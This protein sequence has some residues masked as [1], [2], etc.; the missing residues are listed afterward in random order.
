MKPIISIFSLLTFALSA[1]SQTPA[2]VNIPAEYFHEKVGKQKVEGGYMYTFDA[3]K[4]QDT[5]NET[6]Q[7]N[8][9]VD[10][11]YWGT[12]ADGATGHE[13]LVQAQQGARILIK[14]ETTNNK[15]T[16]ARLT[17]APCLPDGRGFSSDNHYMDIC[18]AF[19]TQTLM[20]Y[21]LRIQRIPDY[22]QSVAI[23]LVKYKGGEVTPITETQRCELYRT[24]CK[25]RVTMENGKLTALIQHD[26]KK[27]TISASTNTSNHGDGFMLQYTGTAGKAASLIQ[28][29]DAR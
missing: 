10:A 9:N 19:N 23:S 25:I 21:G 18:V 15:I 24:E 26:K 17:I 6:W 27:Q 12:A 14:P 8:N 13:G 3:Y 7:P 28:E 4:P 2:T 29:I 11:W 16:S 1:T 22:D 5:Y 20:G